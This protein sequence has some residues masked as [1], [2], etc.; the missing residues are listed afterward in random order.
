[1]SVWTLVS[2]CH[3]TIGSTVDNSGN[4]NTAKFIADGWRER[5]ETSE[6]EL[7]IPLHILQP[8]PLMDKLVSEGKLG[9]KTGEGIFRYIK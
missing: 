3:E 7:H 6:E 4:L 9:R 8:S 5:I 2:T 1:L